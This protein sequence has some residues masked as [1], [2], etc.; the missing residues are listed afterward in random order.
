MQHRFRVY[1]GRAGTDAVWGLLREAWASVATTAVTP[2]QDVLGLGSDARMNV[3]GEATG[4][5][6]WRMRDL[7]WD[8]CGMMRSLSEVYSRK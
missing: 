6:S 5:W 3:P 2:M 7:P 8:K 4:S 1:T